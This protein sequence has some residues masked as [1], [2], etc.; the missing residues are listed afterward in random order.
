MKIIYRIILKPILLMLLILVCMLVVFYLMAPVYTFTEPKPFSGENLYNPYQDMDSSHWKRYNFQVQ[1]KA[2]GGITDGRKNSNLLIDSVYNALGFDHVAT[3]DYQKINYYG[4]GKPSFI[5]TYEH[6][7]NIFKTH[8]VCIGAEKV[9]WTDL[10]LFQTKSMK[11]WIIDQLDGQCEIVSLA[12]PLLK[13]GYTLDDMKYLTNYEMMEVL[14]N[15]RI[16]TEHW[17]VALSSGQV[18]WIMGNDDAHDVMNPNHVGR[19]FTMIN[20]PTTNK[21]DIIEKLKKGNN[22]GVDFYPRMDVPLTERIEHIKEVP[23]VKRVQL[24]GDTLHVKVDQMA[25]EIHFIGQEG[26]IRK[27]LLDTNQAFYVIRSDDSY[28]RTV[29]RFQDGS[30][31]YLNPIIRHEGD[32]P[33][34]LREAY[35]EQKSNIGFANWLFS[36]NSYNCLF[37]QTK[38]TKKR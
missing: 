13:H 25:T 29:F 35:S 11:Q 28:I 7:Y 17:D 38:K 27:T 31:I 36:C 5:P 19:K 12:H 18:V 6:G 20:S 24:I 37:H 8:Q 32:Y 21:E 3:S 14:N 2:W 26:I 34:S 22:Y 4:S 16:S 10:I 33:V 23:V 30:S 9:L 1:S 15:M